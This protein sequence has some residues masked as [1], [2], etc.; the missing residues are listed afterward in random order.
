MKNL[1]L[2]NGLK[3]PFK[4]DEANCVALVSNEED[5]REAI[6]IILCTAPGERVMRPE[7]G[8]GINEYV[9]SVINSSNLLQIENEIERALTIYEPRILI[10][11]V[12]ASAQESANGFLNISI[13][14]E[15]K[16]SNARHNMVYPFYLREKG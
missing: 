5:I 12:D 8:C 13:E 11:D 14:Y 2:G 9:F 6:K 10:I 1:F 15:V 7:F 16:S 3:F 4:I